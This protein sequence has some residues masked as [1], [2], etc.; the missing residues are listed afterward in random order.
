MDNKRILVQAYE[1][2]GF[3]SLDH[4]W[5]SKVSGGKEVSSRETVLIT[6]ETYQALVEASKREFDYDFY[7]G[8]IECG[9]DNMANTYIEVMR[10]E[11]VLGVKD[12]VIGHI[13]ELSEIIADNFNEELTVITK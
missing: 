12:Y 9:L 13:D 10:R 4:E 6:V 1:W 5:I 3:I 2:E 11:V 7:E 8:T